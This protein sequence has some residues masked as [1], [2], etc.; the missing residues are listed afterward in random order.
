MLRLFVA[1][2]P[3]PES[4]AAM[5]A[6]LDG[7]A[8][9]AHARTPVEQVHLTLQFIGDT[10]SRDRE[11][12]LESARRAASGLPK[13]A[14]TPRRLISLPAKAPRLIAMETSAPPQLVELHRRL[15]M[16]LAKSV[17]ARGGDGFLPHLTL[18]RFKHGATAERVNVAVEMPAFEIAG[19]RVMRSTL[20]PG[21]ALHDVVEEIP[22]GA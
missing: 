19:V 16:R 4:A 18:C 20:R 7:L 3:P 11:S 2:Y 17:K 8:L 10:P 13:L 14:L 12:V 15:A 1:A 6:A 5:L 9:P 22:L 21:G